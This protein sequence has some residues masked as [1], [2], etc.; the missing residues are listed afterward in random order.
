MVNCCTNLF[1]ANI[2]NE[3][4]LEMMDKF[5]DEHF[6]SYTEMNDD[7]LDG[8]FGSLC[9]FPKETIDE[10]MKNIQEP[11]KLYIRILSHEL[12]CE[13]VSFRTFSQGKWN[14]HY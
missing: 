12:R 9:K 5:L 14:I 11:Q 7:S 6:E 3:H 4:D 8:E 1:Y 10:M 2:E 13:Y